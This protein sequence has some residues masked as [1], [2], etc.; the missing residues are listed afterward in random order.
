MTH[1]KKSPRRIS[2]GKP[3][4]VLTVAGKRYGLRQMVGQVCWSVAKSVPQICT[5]TVFS[6]FLM[7]FFFFVFFGENHV[8]YVF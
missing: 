2:L 4:S 6:C 8:S 3:R 1:R 5:S 7:L